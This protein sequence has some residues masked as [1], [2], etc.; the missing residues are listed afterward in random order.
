MTKN[1]NKLDN[2]EKKDYNKDIKKAIK[3]IANLD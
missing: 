2:Q 3:T 1:N